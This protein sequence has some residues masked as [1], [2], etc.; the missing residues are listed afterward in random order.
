RE[1]LMGIFEKNG[2]GKTAAFVIPLLQ[3]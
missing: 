2:T 1:L 3:K